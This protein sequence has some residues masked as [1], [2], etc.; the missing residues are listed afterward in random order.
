MAHASSP[1][2]LS[3]LE[4]QHASWC[5]QP[6]SQ[7]CWVAWRDKLQAKLVELQE[8]LLK[9]LRQVRWSGANFELSRYQSWAKL[10]AG[11][12]AQKHAPICNLH[13]A[14]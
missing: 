14:S 11:W 3:L 1:L 12:P 9:L 10:Q 2:R 13:T 8:K 5:C 6:L 7:G 4:C